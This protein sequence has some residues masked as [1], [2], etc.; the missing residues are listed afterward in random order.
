MLVA[1]ESLKLG[2]IK[3]ETLL[4][5]CAKCNNFY[6]ISLGTAIDSMPEEMKEYVK[7]NHILVFFMQYKNQ[8]FYDP[9]ILNS[10][11]LNK[12]IFSTLS[13]ILL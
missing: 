1:L 12:P 2:M 8:V 10:T 7:S 4:K 13:S 5:K 3:V 6:Q 11:L 9:S